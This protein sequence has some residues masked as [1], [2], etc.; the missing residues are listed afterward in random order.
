MRYTTILAL[1]DEAELSESGSQL[2]FA[3][4]EYSLKYADK[5]TTVL[6]VGGQLHG[7]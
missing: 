5:L 7:K 6:I 1:P 2:F 3:T 4:S